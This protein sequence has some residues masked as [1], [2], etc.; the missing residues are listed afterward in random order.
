MAGSLLPQPKQLF[1]DANWNPLI[2]GQIFTYAAGTLTPKTTYQDAALTIANTSPTLANARGEVLMFGLG[3]YRIILKDTLGNTIYDVDNVESSKSL[4]DA[5]RAELSLATGASLIGYIAPGAATSQQTIKSVLDNRVYASS[6]GMAP[7][8]T[9]ERNLAALNAN[10]AAIESTGLPG[11]IRIPAGYYSVSGTF[12]YNPMLIQLQGEGGVTLDFSAVGAGT[13][14]KL[15]SIGTAGESI[16]RNK[17]RWSGGLTLKGAATTLL[18][19]MTATG[20]VDN[21]A[22]T[23]RNICFDTFAEGIR[24][25]SNAWQLTLQDYAFTNAAVGAPHINELSDAAEVNYGE[26]NRFLSGLHSGLGIAY[27]SRNYNSDAHFIGCS[28]DCSQFVDIARGARVMHANC[29]YETAADTAILFSVDGD[30]GGFAQTMLSIREGMLVLPG[31]F[32]TFSVMSCAANYPVTGGG[33]FIDGLSIACSADF[34]L[35]LNKLVTGDGPVHA[36]A[37]RSG[38]QFPTF[39]IANSLNQ[40]TSGSF[41]FPTFLLTDFA[42]VDASFPPTID[43]TVFYTIANSLKMQAIGAAFVGASLTKSVVPGQ[44]G[45]FGFFYKLASITGGAFFVITTKIFDKKGNVV[46]INDSVVLSGT[47]DWT[48]YS[49]TNLRTIIMPPGADHIYVAVQVNSGGGSGTA[50]VDDLCLN[51]ID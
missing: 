13:A 5:L 21:A 12:T 29:H 26:C 9:A 27:K 7:A 46:A 36:R 32:R 44:R 24:L 15:Q 10:K 34:Q 51:L 30:V 18:L 35:P 1:Q 38:Y 4:V 33:I 45:F 50:W 49:N 40:T 23:F 16:S 19:D 11:V 20:G 8:A 47:N 14:I 37:I 6:Y 43:S 3:A 2:G 22:A 28:F 25:A 41:E 39:A 17:M 48:F 42:A 31:T